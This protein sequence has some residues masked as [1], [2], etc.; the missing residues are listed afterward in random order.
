MN[1]E[2][3]VGNL[4]G[5]A[6]TAIPALRW[7]ILAVSV[8]VA[9]CALPGFLAFPR[10]LGIA[11]GFRS[12]A[13]LVAVTGIAFNSGFLLEGVRMAPPDIR[14]VFNL[15]VFLAAIILAGG[16]LWIFRRVKAGHLVDLFD[17]IDATGPIAQLWKID[18]DAAIALAEEAKRLTVDRHLERR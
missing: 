14:I 9:V 15:V 13:F 1:L 11:T 17:A 16:G 7:I 4:D 6:A 5:I 2:S 3:L 12:L 8:P 18:P 10:R